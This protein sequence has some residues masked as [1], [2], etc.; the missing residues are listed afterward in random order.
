MLEGLIV[1][2]LVVAVLTVVLR[3]PTEAARP[4]R[5]D[6][7]PQRR[8]TPTEVE[9]R[10]VPLSMTVTDAGGATR[11]ESLGEIDFDQIERDVA[12]DLRRREEWRRRPRTAAEPDPVV[13]GRPLAEWI[14]EL[15][16]R[17]IARRLNAVHT[18]KRVGLPAEAALPKLWELGRHRD[19]E[20]AEAA[21]DA[22]MEIASDREEMI[23][24]RELM[25]RRFY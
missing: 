19:R 6:T 12:A 16:Q 23:R 2:G 11:T 24:A 1:A 13:D 18:L 10:V 15:G 3:R 5:P 14:A 22:I 21:L 8:G 9:R 25:E 4:T 7:S 20:L 17:S